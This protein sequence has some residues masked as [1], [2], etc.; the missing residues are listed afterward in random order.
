M[1]LLKDLRIELSTPIPIYCDNISSMQLAKNPVFYART[2][3]IKVNYHF[4]C[5][6]VLSGEVKLRYIRTNGQVPNIFTKPL[7]LEKLQ[8]YSEMLG[9]QHLDVP[10]LRG[11][12]S[13]RSYENNKNSDDEQEEAKQKWE[14]ESKIA[15][16]DKRDDL[17]KL[18][19]V[20]VEWTRR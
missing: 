8:H 1:R 14:D 11:R 3:H 2:K 16:S 9:L 15:Y 20:E 19:H 13:G 17:D 5:E 4:V 6:E 10:H 7:R 12:T 18:D